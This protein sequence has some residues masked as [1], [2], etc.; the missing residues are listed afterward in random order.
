SGIGKSTLLKTITGRI[1]PTNGSIRFEGRPIHTG[2]FVLVSQ[3]VWLFNA[4]LRENITLYQSYSDETLHHILN[5]VGLDRELG[6]NALE[7]RIRDNGSNLSGGQAQRI[8]IARGLL[9]Q[10]PI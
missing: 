10:S 2:D 5:L 4:T 6:N 1:K 7:T 9:R 3:D 8:A